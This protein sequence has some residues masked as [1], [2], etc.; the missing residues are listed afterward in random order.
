MMGALD[1]L[2][3]ATTISLTTFSVMTLRFEG[4]IVILLVVMTNSDLN[5]FRQNSS[6]YKEAKNNES[7]YNGIQ[8]NDSQNN[9]TQYNE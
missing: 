8:Y 3:G 6:Q 1:N 5:A 9:D 7:Q 4:K 2:D